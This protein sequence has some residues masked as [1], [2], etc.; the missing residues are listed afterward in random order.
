MS[1]VQ[2]GSAVLEKGTLGL[3]DATPIHH[4]FASTLVGMHEACQ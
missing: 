2:A 4:A 1:G 3:G